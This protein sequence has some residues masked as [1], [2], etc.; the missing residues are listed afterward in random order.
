MDANAGMGEA[1]TAARAEVEQLKQDRDAAP[2]HA[3]LEV[4]D[5]LD[6]ELIHTQDECVQFVR[7]VA[8][9]YPGGAYSGEPEYRAENTRLDA[10]VERLRKENEHLTKL[11]KAA[12]EYGA[13]RG[14]DPLTYGNLDSEEEEK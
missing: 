7:D 12:D 6:G 5:R 14:C 9:E 3:L 8:E 11:V 4:A 2:R 1:L 10:E 13:M